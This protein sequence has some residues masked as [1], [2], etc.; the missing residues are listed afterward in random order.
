MSR[1][2]RL[3]GALCFLAALAQAPAPAAV[4]PPDAPPADAASPVPGPTPDAAPPPPAW[5]PR[6]GA[7]LVLLDKIS[8]RPTMLQLRV[9]QTASAGSLTIVLRACLVR[10][11][12]RPE[13][14]AAFMD[15]TDTHPGQPGFHGWMLADEPSVSMLQHPIYDLRLTGCVG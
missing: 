7:S 8:A 2:R 3:A 15:I 1:A 6:G 4:P 9:G 13:D 5:V 12:D 10:P 14:A 11:P